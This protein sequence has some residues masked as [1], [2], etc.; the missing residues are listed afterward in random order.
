VR[1]ALTWPR[2]HTSPIPPGGGVPK[3]N[4]DAKAAIQGLVPKHPAVG[5]RPMFGNLAGSRP[6]TCSPGC[7]AP[8][9]SSD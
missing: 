1:P 5:I 8:T 9:C 7:S 6:A 4:A 2:S 3:P